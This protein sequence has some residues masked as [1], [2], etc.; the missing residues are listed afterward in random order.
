MSPLTVLILIACIVGAFG[1]IDE[2]T[3][4]NFSDLPSSSEDLYDQISESEGRIVNG[5]FARPAQFPHQVSIRILGSHHVCGGSILNRLFILTAAQ[6]TQG[7]LS[8]PAN[9]TVVVGG[10]RLV[11]SGVFYRV[12]SIYNHP[13]FNRTTR[14]NDISIIRTVND[15]LFTERIRPV[16]LPISNVPVEGT[17]RVTISGWGRLTVRIINKLNLFVKSSY[18]Q[19][20]I[21][22]IIKS[23]F[24]YYISLTYFSYLISRII[25]SY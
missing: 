4:L 5:R 1:F 17:L 16:I 24:C 13:E 7:H 10:L 15:I 2:A 18:F 19:R 20:Y 8:I 12:R 3:E 25:N 11:N 6:C 22:I 14:S 9:V 23:F 21:L